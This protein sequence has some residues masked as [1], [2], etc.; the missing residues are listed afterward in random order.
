MAS[1]KGMFQNQNYETEVILDQACRED[2]MWWI[3]CLETS[4]GRSLINPKKEIHI[5]TDASNS[6]WGAWKGTLQINGLWTPEESTY[7]INAKEL[8]AGMMAV[9]T[10]TKD[11]TKSAYG[12]TITRL[13]KNV[14]TIVL[15]D[16]IKDPD[17]AHLLEKLL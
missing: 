5:T 10:F 4:N 8:K 3:Q 16:N 2:L 7:H 1:A 6:G 9:K 15:C 17:V 12:D 13:A 14:R 11:K